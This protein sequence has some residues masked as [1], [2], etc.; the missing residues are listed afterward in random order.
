M[1]A[2]A[3]TASGSNADTANHAETALSK[4]KGPLL[5][6][7]TEVCCLSK[8]HQWNPETWWWNEEVDKAIREKRAPV[9]KA[10]LKKMPVL[11][12]ILRNSNINL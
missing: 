4:L 3:A 10:K 5:D 6:A 1:T 7:A 8:N 2:A 11:I 9:F 12:R